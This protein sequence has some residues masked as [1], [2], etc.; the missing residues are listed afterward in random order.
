MPPWRLR[1]I[2]GE[3]PCAC[4]SWPSDLAP[5]HPRWN[6]KTCSIWMHLG[7]GGYGKHYGWPGK[8]LQPGFRNPLELMTHSVI[9]D[10]SG[11]NSPPWRATFEGPFH[12]R[13]QHPYQLQTYLASPA[14]AQ[15]SKATTGGH[16]RDQVG[17][18]LPA[19][20]MVF[21]TLLLS[22]PSMNKDVETHLGSSPNKWGTYPC[23][24]G[25]CAGNH[26]FL[27]FFMCYFHHVWRLLVRFPLVAHLD[28][29]GADWLYIPQL[30]ALQEKPARP[31][32]PQ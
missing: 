28:I 13:F 32:M 17:I 7:Y 20:L 5:G 1:L 15:A 6:T 30:L 16:R 27:M 10:I 29:E 21:S 12:H 24:Q 14:E 31:R 19:D 8:L 25:K 22:S 26:C 23:L 3:V 18:T 11:E 2:R 4:P 9:L